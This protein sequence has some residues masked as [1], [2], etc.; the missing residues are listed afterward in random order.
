MKKAVGSL[1]ASI[2]VCSMMVPAFAENK[3]NAQLRSDFKIEIDGQECVFTRAD[4]STALPILYNDTTYLPLRAIGEIMGK[5]VN[6]DEI[7]KTINISGDRKETTK[8]TQTATAESKEVLVQERGDFLIEIDG[9]TM[10]FRTSSGVKISPIVYNGSTYLPLRAIGQIMGKDVAWDNTTKKVSLAP[11]DSAVTDADSFKT[12]AD[13][14]K[15]AEKGDIG[16]GKAK[17]IA[18]AHAKLEAK[19]VRFVKT[20]MDKDDG[21]KVYEVE[22]YHGNNE[23]DYKIDAVTGEIVSVDNEIEDFDV[24][25]DGKFINEEQAKKAATAH[26]N[27]KN[28]DATFTKA[29]LDKDDDK[30]VYEINFYTTSAE[31]EYTIDATKATVL[32]FE[33]EEKEANADAKIISLAEAKKAALSHAGVKEKDVKFTK[34][35]L[36][37]DDKEKVYKLEFEGNDAKYEYIIDGQTGKVLD[38]DK[39]QLNDDDDDNKTDKKNGKGNDKKDEKND[40]AD[41]D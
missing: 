16:M 29:E 15:D 5:N 3:T 10:D 40:D 18:L 28:S 21:K 32:S 20:K 34:A 7:N 19:D 25:K 1:I 39:E 24:L 41:E 37:T 35:E 22:F 23:Y 14:V 11:S 30:V 4:G 6:W 27:V 9:V 36:D 38:S 33:K 12:D 17:E 2:L 31:Y 13:A 8:N 26:A